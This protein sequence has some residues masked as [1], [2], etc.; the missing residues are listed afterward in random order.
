MKDRYKENH[1]WRIWFKEL[2]VEGFDLTSSKELL[3]RLAKDTDEDYA[4]FLVSLFEQKEKIQKR[5]KVIPRKNENESEKEEEN[6]E[7]E[8]P[9]YAMF[10]EKLVEDGKAYKLKTSKDDESPRFLVYEKPEESNEYDHDLPTRGCITMG[11]DEDNV[12]SSEN[13]RV[14]RRVSN[15]TR[16]I[17]T[18]EEVSRENKTSEHN[19]II[20][21]QKGLTGGSCYELLLESNIPSEYGAFQYAGE[22]LKYEENVTSSSSDSDIE[23]LENVKDFNEVNNKALVPAKESLK[24]QLIRILEKPYKKKEHKMLSKYLMEEKPICRHIDLRERPVSSVLKGMTKSLFDDS[25]IS[26]QVMFR[27]NK[28]DSLKAINL[29]R[30]FCFW[31][32]HVP[33]Q[34]VFRPWDD[35]KILKILPRPRPPRTR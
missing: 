5:S 26:F 6:N 14:K 2:D 24:Q 27:K 29:L 19:A 3:D 12:N 16:D 17:L 33:N 31:L 8:D 15:E 7:K 22:P 11:D 30:M 18:T 10:F 13:R 4:W 20:E 23:I 25:P 9:Q 21:V 28:N 34:D 32:V 1:K 35:D